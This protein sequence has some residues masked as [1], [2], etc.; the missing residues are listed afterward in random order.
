MEVVQKK[1]VDVIKVFVVDGDL[2]VDGLFLDLNFFIS[3]VSELNCFDGM[4]IKWKLFICGKV[5]VF[6]CFEMNFKFIEG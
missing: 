6:K 3:N 4:I 2:D 1:I 5:I